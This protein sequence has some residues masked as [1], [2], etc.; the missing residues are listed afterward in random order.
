MKKYDFE[1]WMKN[2]LKPL[3]MGIVNTTP[4]S[5]SDGGVHSSAGELI[6]FA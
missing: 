1:N 3:I 4:D 6:D 2:P 5:F